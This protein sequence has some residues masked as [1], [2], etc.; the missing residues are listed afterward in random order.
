MT[1]KWFYRVYKVGR[2]KCCHINLRMKSLLKT[3][4]LNFA[5]VTC[6]GNRSKSLFYQ[7]LFNKLHHRTNLI[8][9]IFN[10]FVFKRQW[11]TQNLKILSSKGTSH[12]NSSS[13]WG[14][15]SFAQQIS[16]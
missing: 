7:V 10:N 1:L 12:T 3:S 13:E 6:M 14:H 15:D 11:R 16:P 2:E 9:F 5:L 4:N 8:A